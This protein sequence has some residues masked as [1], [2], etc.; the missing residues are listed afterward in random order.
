MSD[1]TNSIYV[2]LERI[3]V[4]LESI[5][6][7]KQEKQVTPFPWH[8]MDTRV[9]SVLGRIKDEWSDSKLNRYSYPLSCEDLVAIGRDDI[10]SLRNIGGLS[11]D[12][13]A[14]E[15]QKRGFSDW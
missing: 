5:S 14:K 15:L 7:T 4:A 13:I 10:R 2:L 3:A 12:K 11:C 1:E 9:R 6:D 8:R